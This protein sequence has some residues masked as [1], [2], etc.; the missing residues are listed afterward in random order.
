MRRRSTRNKAATTS[1]TP[2]VP[3]LREMSE[4]ELARLK[5][6]QEN[7]AYLSTLKLKD[8]RTNIKNAGVF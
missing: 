3:K 8:A 4:Y 7:K 2:P 6:I 1:V 5:Q